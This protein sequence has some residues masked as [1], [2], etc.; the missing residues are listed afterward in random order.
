[1]EQFK[2]IMQDAQAEI[3]E[4]KSRFIANVYYIENAEEAEE[5]LKQ[6][7]KK[8]FDARHNCFA[9]R[10]LEENGVKEKQSDDGEPSGTAGAPML[11]ILQKNN[12]YNVLIVVTRYFGGTLLGTGGLVRAYSYATIKSL[13]NAKVI[14]QTKGYLIN[15]VI[16][17]KDLEKFKYY[18]RMHGIIIVN[19]VYENNIICTME[20]SK[21]EKENLLKKE[22]KE[23]QILK[24]TVIKE[25]Y[26]RVNVEE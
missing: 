21:N 3:E 17:Y 6:I 26:I 8:Y 1:M 11:N 24:N 12:L 15:V 22:Q 4:K 7:R 16:E 25:K 19:T 18:C 13:E 9:Y 23:I 5:H 10:I 2:T 20:I 14:I